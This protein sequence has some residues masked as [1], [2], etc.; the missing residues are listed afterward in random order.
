MIV[1]VLFV[2]LVAVAAVIVAARF[3]RP[4]RKAEPH[5]PSE[6]PAAAMRA[7][8][9]ALYILHEVPGSAMDVSLVTASGRAARFHCWVKDG[10]LLFFPVWDDLLDERLLEVWRIPTEDIICHATQQGLPCRFT[11]LQY[12][13]GEA[14]LSLAFPEDASRVFSAL[15]PEKDL[16]HLLV[17][18]YPKSSRNIHDIKESFVSLK[19][20]RGEELIT[21]DEYAAKKKEMLI[22]M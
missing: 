1:G 19:E 17:E 18:M 13:A 15:L 3:A 6:D 10:G 9:D 22:S 8:Y 2:A 5:P 20:L 12:R 7:R 16:S 14:A 4:R 21:E 11:V